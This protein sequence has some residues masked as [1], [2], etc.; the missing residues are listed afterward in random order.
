MGSTPAFSPST[1]PGEGGIRA[2]AGGIL[3]LTVATFLA[4]TTE[5]LPVGVLPAMSEDLAVEE[6]VVGLL[7]TV[8]AVMVALLAV[9][10]TIWTR[11]VSRKGLLL[12]TIAAY[13]AANLIVALAP[14]FAV[15]AA[16]RAIGGF[17]HALF[18]SLSIAYCSRLV[19]PEFVGR[20]LAIVTAG[21]SAGFV[22]GVPLS[23]AIGTAIGWRAAFGVL[24]AACA[25]TFL[26]VALLLPPVS[27]A[28][29]GDREDPERAQ[30]RGRL[31]VVSVANAL[32]YLGQYSVYTYIAV[33]LLA[34]GLTA[35][36]LGPVLL[37]L[38]GLG[39]VGTWYA[40]VTLDQ[41]PRSSLLVLLAA[42]TVALVLMG[43]V[44]P[45]LIGVLLASA[46]WGAGFG[47]VASSFQTAAI[48]T[49]GATPDLIGALVN[50]TANLGIGAGAAIGG[51]ILTGVG[52][53]WL[54]YCGALLVAVGAVVVT[55]ARRSFP[56]VPVAGPP[57]PVSDE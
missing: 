54:P 47:G 23:T 55:L 51:G 25:A 49:G 4:I 17:A 44:F 20:A 24:A 33:I 1:A 8:Y 45:A 42:I 19:R 27:L 32:V 39:L 38:G 6:S 36:G 37:V 50:A 5:M 31:A 2:A 53:E 9:P 56:S 3:A 16:G 7:V 43:L 41:R 10:L 46:L 48:R 29:A 40:G 52:L 26:L 13:L 34:S 35:A 14:S 12:A 11:R 22:L 21:A 57:R 30:R 28:P 18:F 15:V